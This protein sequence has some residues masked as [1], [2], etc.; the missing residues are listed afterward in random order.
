MAECRHSGLFHRTRR[1]GGELRCSLLT[2]AA[3]VEAYRL[4]TLAIMFAPVGHP[5][6]RRR[7][8]R[9]PAGIGIKLDRWLDRYPMVPP[10]PYTSR[11]DAYKRAP[12][13]IPRPRRT[14]L[15]E[16]R[17]EAL[18]ALLR[19]DELVIVSGDC[20]PTDLRPLFEIMYNATG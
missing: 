5:C 6:R 17:E 8:P 7:R 16:C 9:P 19:R 10:H 11:S 4:P 18:T 1:R 3:I 13:Q 14:A 20:P 12:P 2:N 15:G